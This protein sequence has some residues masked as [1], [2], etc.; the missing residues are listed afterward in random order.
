L[1]EQGEN[2]DQKVNS[3]VIFFASKNKIC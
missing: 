3:T 1:L 2:F